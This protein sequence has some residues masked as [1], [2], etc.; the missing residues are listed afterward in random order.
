MTRFST[1]T[2]AVCFCSFL[3]CSKA[4]AILFTFELFLSLTIDEQNR[5]VVNLILCNRKGSYLHS[6]QSKYQI[7][8]MVFL[9]S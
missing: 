1:W 6:E 5:L 9:P 2:E 7:C 3:F 8:H 4:D